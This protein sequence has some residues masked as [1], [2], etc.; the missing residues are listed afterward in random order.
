MVT[1]RSYFLLIIVLGLAVTGL[2]VRKAL[3]TPVTAHSDAETARW[4]AMGDYYT[5]KLGLRSQRS[6][7]AETARWVAM[8]EFHTDRQVQEAQRSL[9]TSLRSRNAETARWVAMGKYYTRS[10][11]AET[12]RWNAMAEFYA[13]K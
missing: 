10:R 4:V 6:L 9:R 11:A 12:A 13:S 2:T 7:A 5:A 3:A 8:G 1:K